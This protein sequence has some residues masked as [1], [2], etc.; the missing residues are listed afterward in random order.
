MIEL[1]PEDRIR[2]AV[3]TIEELC[4]QQREWTSLDF[5]SRLERQG[6]A[7]ESVLKYAIRLAVRRKWMENKGTATVPGKNRQRQVTI[8]RSL[9]FGQRKQF[10]ERKM[11]K[12]PRLRPVLYEPRTEHGW[13][14]GTSTTRQA[15]MVFL[16]EAGEVGVVR[17]S[18]DGLD[19]TVLSRSEAASLARS[20]RQKQSLALGRAAVFM[21][22]SRVAGLRLIPQ[23][24]SAMR[25]NAKRELSSAHGLLLL[26]RRLGECAELSLAAVRRFARTR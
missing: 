20:A 16:T 6:L 19:T 24:A 14:T 7:P 15:P 5:D 22:M 25:R 23:S 11:V 8:W 26:S 17:D 3:E 4:L 9:I 1:K 21:G 2:I 13:V 18:A 12:Y 10:Y